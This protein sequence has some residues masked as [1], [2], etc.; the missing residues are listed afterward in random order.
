MFDVSPEIRSIV[1]APKLKPLS[2]LNDPELKL[3]MTVNFTC[4]TLP[5]SCEGVTTE[6]MNTLTDIIV[7]TLSNTSGEHGYSEVS[8]QVACP[9]GMRTVVGAASSSSLPAQ[10]PFAPPSVINQ[11]LFIHNQPKV[12]IIAEKFLFHG[13]KHSDF[14]SC[15]RKDPPPGSVNRCQFELIYVISH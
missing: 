11:C 12:C 9:K 7:L 4:F 8:L 14:V 2:I 15:H 1:S 13:T 5:S 10:T 6:E 3:S